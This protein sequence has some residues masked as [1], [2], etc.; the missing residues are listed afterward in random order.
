MNAPQKMTNPNM[1]PQAGAPAS[2]KFKPIDPM[3]V[4]REHLWILITVSLISPVIGGGV[5]FGLDKIMPKW[6]SQQMFQVSPGSNNA[7]DPSG[8]TQLNT[9][10]MQLIEAYIATQTLRIQSEQIL[11]KALDSP[12]IQN[13]TWYQKF[14]N[15]KVKARKALEDGVVKS[16]SPRDSTA[17]ILSVSTSYEQDSNRILEAIADTYIKSLNA[18]ANSEF[19]ELDRSFLA[20]VNHSSNRIKSLNREIQ[21]FAK[22]HQIVTSAG[23]R[24]QLE[25]EQYT[26]QKVIFEA[27]LD[28]A[29]KQQ[30]ML[31]AQAN[32]P[33]VEPNAEDLQAV[34]QMPEI[35][36]LQ[37][38]INDEE[39]SYKGLLT[40]YSEKHQ[41]S[42]QSKSR[43]ESYREQLRLSTERKLREMEAFRLKNAQ[44]TIDSLTSQLEELNARLAPAEKRLTDLNAQIEQYNQMLIDLEQTKELK[45]AAEQALANSRVYQKRPDKE[46]IKRIGGATLPVKTFPKPLL[47][48]PGV[49]F[50]LVGLTTGLIFLREVLDQRVKSPSDIKL[51]PDSS[52]LSVIPSI[53]DDKT[54]HAPIEEVVR[55]YPTSLLAESYRQARTSILN[56]MEKKGYKTLMVVATQPGSGA[57]TTVQNI[58]SSMA[59]NGRNVLILDANIRRPKAHEIADI[60]NKGWTN[61]IGN[62]AALM[63]VIHAGKPGEPSILCVGNGQIRPEL[64]ESQDFKQMIDTLKE[65]FDYILIDAPPLLL[66]SEGQVLTKI[67]DAVTIVVNANKDQRGVVQRLQGKLKGN[68]ADV[69]GIILNEVSASAGGY[70]KKNYQAFYKYSNEANSQ[71]TNT[72]KAEAVA[73]MTD[74]NH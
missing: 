57:T 54:S 2:G 22:D 41:I 32:S 63:Q 27:Q 52:L 68:H 21:A 13:T 38:R 62:N 23:A 9:G 40:M 43:V 25:V 17:I 29:I 48:V 49:M 1:M 31:L 18:D 5:W 71:Q 20:E 53:N 47:V 65:Q 59:A 19:R 26:E 60:T 7:Y 72:E 6:T 34:Q 70:F 50:V 64:F 46:R 51:I 58:A 73:S 3:R 42:R 28:G 33:E 37:Q 74:H 10:Q 39:A 35:L 14:D 30:Q 67:I 61:A 16:Y 55:N 66:T 12:L 36:S 69:L 4:L 45:N 24:A 56:K 44:Q 8:G 15:D 11:D